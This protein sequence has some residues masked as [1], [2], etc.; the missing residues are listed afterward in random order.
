MKIENYIRLLGILLGVGILDSY[1]T[2]NNGF[3]LISQGN[4]SSVLAEIFRWSFGLIAAILLLRVRKSAQWILLFAFM[5][6]L[7]ATWV[8][9]IPF[10]G[11]LMRL[12]DQSSTI[13]NFIALQTP[14]LILVLVVF[15]LFR[16]LKKS[17]RVTGGF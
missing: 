2:L 17:N 8:S 11:Y 13:Q 10:A 6:G 9:F 1:I 5:C 12:A 14:N 4:I 16:T 7:V 3:L 15:F